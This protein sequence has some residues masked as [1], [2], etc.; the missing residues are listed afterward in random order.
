MTNLLQN[1]FNILNE[2]YLKKYN[3]I[4]KNKQVSIDYATS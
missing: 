3:Q 4:I 1:T 2:A